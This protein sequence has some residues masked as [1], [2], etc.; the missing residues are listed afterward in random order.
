MHNANQHRAAN[1]TLYKVSFFCI[2]Q[3]Y[4]RIKPKL[5]MLYGS[6]WKAKERKGIIQAVLLL[7]G[8]QK[9]RIPQDNVNHHLSTTS[10]KPGAISR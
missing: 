5:E 9:G 2:Q 3:F 7:Q 10:S 8:G 4:K 1:I 6:F